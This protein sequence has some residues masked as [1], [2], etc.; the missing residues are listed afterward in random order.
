M[1]A[2]NIT[3]PCTVHYVSY[4]TKLFNSGQ[5]YYNT[6]LF[7]LCRFVIAFYTK[8]VW[9]ALK[10]KAVYDKVRLICFVKQMYMLH[11]YAF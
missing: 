1:K 2:R 10:K 4:S 9:L 3:K 6:F 7:L 5:T 8:T 11:K